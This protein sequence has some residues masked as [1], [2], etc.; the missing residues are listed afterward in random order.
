MKDHARS[1]S[2][3]ALR[4]IVILTL[5]CTFAP[6][7]TTQTGS[8]SP[9]PDGNISKDEVTRF[10]SQEASIQDQEAQANHDYERRPL[11]S[12][13]AGGVTGRF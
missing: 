8:C 2:Q 11:R 9:P 12:S 1:I 7:Q 13:E 6:A 3:Q 4:S 5:L 10:E